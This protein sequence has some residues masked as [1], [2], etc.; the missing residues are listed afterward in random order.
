MHW[1][2]L[3]RRQARWALA[4]SKCRKKPS[5]FNSEEQHR[6]PKLSRKRETTASRRSLFLAPAWSMSAMAAFLVL[7]LDAGSPARAQLTCPPPP[8]L[9]QNGI[10]L[11]TI[12]IFNNDPSNKYLFPVLTTGVKLEDI[13]MQAWFKV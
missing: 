10:C 8:A 9:Q 2:R 11:M 13:W 4:T 3:V 5:P 1:N 7:C 12:K 6:M